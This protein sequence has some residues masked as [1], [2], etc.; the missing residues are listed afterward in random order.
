M[1]CAFQ[2]ICAA[3]GS[4]SA[5]FVFER[6]AFADYLKDTFTT[7]NADYHVLVL[8]EFTSRATDSPDWDFSSAPLM[9]VGRFVELFSSKE[10][11]PTL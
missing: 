2:L 3:D 5:P 1:K 6:V 7:D 8:C 10:E 4:R 9:N 11:Q